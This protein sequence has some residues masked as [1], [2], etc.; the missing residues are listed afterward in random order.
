M[1]AR[2]GLPLTGLQLHLGAYQLGPL[3]PAGPPIHGV[4]VQYPVPVERFALAAAHLRATAERVGGITWL[5]LGGGWPAAAGLGEH[6]GRRARG[7]RPAPRR[8]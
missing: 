3:P 8:T 2:A 6:L 5:D 1:L 7:P 4:T